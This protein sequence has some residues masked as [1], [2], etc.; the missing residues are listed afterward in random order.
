MTRKK[1][2]ALVKQGVKLLEPVLRQE[3]ALVPV[4]G[5]KLAQQAESQAPALPLEQLKKYGLLAGGA[6][7]VLGAAQSVARTQTLRLALALELKKQ[8]KP[9]HDKLDALEKENAELKKRL[10]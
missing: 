9:I 3:A 2:K 6:V 5:K 10:K 7:L 4:V 8:L 1:K